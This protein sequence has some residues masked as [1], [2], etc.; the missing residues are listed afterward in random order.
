M[1]ACV[2]PPGL[3]P[4]DGACRV[5]SVKSRHVESG[6]VASCQVLSSRVELC[7]VSPVL[8]GL[9]TS[10]YVVSRCVSCVKSC[11]VR[12]C[13]VELRRVASVKSS[14]VPPCPVTS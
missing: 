3:T 2:A 13:L 4:S 1:G 8:S 14:H 10:R 6:Q 9:D 11:H 5:M 12:S 7:L